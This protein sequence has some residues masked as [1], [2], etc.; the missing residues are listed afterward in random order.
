M[1]STAPASSWPRMN[2]AISA[3]R[4]L[5][6]PEVPT[7]MGMPAPVANSTMPALAAGCVTSSATSA[8]SI[9]SRLERESSAA[10]SSRSSDASMSSIAKRPIL[11]VAPATATRI[12]TCFT[13][14]TARRAD[15]RT[16]AVRLGLLHA[17]P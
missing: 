7:T 15:R 10:C 2:W 5:D 12:V 9:S 6:Q 14:A 16:F 17:I 3:M 11:P 13:L 8:P 1:N 4:S